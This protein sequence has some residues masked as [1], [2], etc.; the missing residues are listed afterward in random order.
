MS[1]TLPTAHR[2]YWVLPKWCLLLKMRLSEKGA[3]LPLVDVETE[4]PEFTWGESKIRL[5]GF[6][7]AMH[8]HACALWL[9]SHLMRLS[10]T[11]WER[12]DRENELCLAELRLE[13]RVARRGCR[14]PS[15][16]LLRSR[17]LKIRPGGTHIITRMNP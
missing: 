2:R 14:C 6:T 10:P 3:D 8:G 17:C 13:G 1:L 15:G 7:E 9:P 12:G 11:P 4:R 16:A 5:V